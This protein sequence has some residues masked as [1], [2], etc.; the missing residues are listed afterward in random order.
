M[1]LSLLVSST[2]SILYSGAIV[3]L[4]LYKIF[5]TKNADGSAHLFAAFVIGVEVLFRMSSG[6]LGYEFGKYATMMFLIFGLMVERRK[7]ATPVTFIVFLLLLLPSI[8]VLD[9]P[10]FDDARQE[11]SF[12]LSGPICVGISVIYF[13]K[14]KLN[15]AQLRRVLITILYPIT[16]LSIYLYFRSG[17]LE[18]IKYTTE[19]NFQASGGFGPNQVST[20]FGLGILVIAISY[21]LNIRLFRI[22]YLN[23]ILLFTF[24]I[25]GLATFSRGGVIAPLTAVILCIIIMTLTNQKFYL[26]IGKI[27]YAF[28]LLATAAF[29]GFNY[30]NDISGG[31]LEMRFKGESKSAVDKEANL[32]NGRDDILMED[33]N[34]FSKNV[35]L[36]VGPGMSGAKR[37]EYGGNGVEAHVEFS[38]LLS[39]HGIFGLVA[40]LILVFFPV[41]NFAKLNSI[42]DKILL[43]LC[44]VFSLLTMAHAATRIAAPCFMYGFA[45]INLI[46]IRK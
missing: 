43:I 37:E 23:I 16:A 18:G 1:A 40:V 34:V 4:G 44:V 10:T 39:E 2:L 5:K 7:R 36:G 14:R 31:L 41:V 46:R 15:P 24:L 20:V 3:V 30:V 45:Y 12:N 17:D 22:K 29:L 6:A 33:L 42:D 25:R 9:Y 35:L 28:L 19:S 26:R 13:Y 21:F 8:F 11:I 32:F 27:V 38:R